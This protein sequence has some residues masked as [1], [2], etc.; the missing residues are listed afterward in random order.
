MWGMFDIEIARDGSFA[1]VAFNRTATAAWG[2]HLNAVK[3]LEVSPCT[4]CLNTSNVHKLANGDI[5]VDISITHPYDNPVYTGFDVRGIIMFPASQV[6]PDNE[7]RSLLGL[8]PVGSWQYRISRHEKGDA[9]LMNPEGWTMIWAPG[10]KDVVFGYDGQ[11]QLEYGYPIFDYYPGKYA[12]GEN[13]GSINAFR[14]FYSNVNRHMF[15]AGKTVT[16]TY[17]I[18]PPA[19]GPIEASYAVYAHWAEPLKIPVT[20]PAVDF[21]PEA[22]SPMP[23]EMWITQD[24]VIDPDAPPEEKVKHI[25]WHIKTWDI[26]FEYWGAEDRNLTYCYGYTSLQAHPS[27]ESDDYCLVGFDTDCY[28]G[29]PDAYPGKWL[30]LFKIWIQDPNEPWYPIA[31]GTEWVLA[32]IEIGPYDGQW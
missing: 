15:E 3:L 20:D 11:F 21:G 7:L 19:Q 23:Y 13:L 18:R 6:Y 29:L 17:I 4:N 5:S 1:D 8:E 12:S 9:E 28:G 26:G 10:M 25:H 14:R 24:S 2:Y 27:G 22:N 32:D 30:Y 16:R 31:L